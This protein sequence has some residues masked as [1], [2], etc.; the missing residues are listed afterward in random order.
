M[1]REL[2]PAHDRLDRKPRM[3]KTVTRVLHVIGGLFYIICPPWPPWIIHKIAFRAPSKGEYYF[4]TAR[5]AEGVKN[6]QICLP[7]LLRKKLKAIDIYYHILRCKVLYEDLRI[8]AMEIMCEQTEK[9]LRRTENRRTRSPKLIIFAQPNSSDIG[10]CM[11]MDPNFADI[12]DFLRCDLLVFDYAGYGIS[13][14]EATEQTVYDS[15]DR[16]YKYATEDLGYVPKDIILIG[17]SLGTAAMV[18]IFVEFFHKDLFEPKNNYNNKL[19]DDVS[20]VTVH[21]LLPSLDQFVD[22]DSPKIGSCGVEEFVEPVFKVPF[23]IEGNTPIGFNIER[24]R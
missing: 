12:A 5:D 8:C 2:C 13:D 4:L 22:G 14:G 23:A 11:L 15:V 19:T 24:K 20:S 18:H 7:H 17:F 3:L 1:K 21:D 6:L 10:C 16:V 9:W